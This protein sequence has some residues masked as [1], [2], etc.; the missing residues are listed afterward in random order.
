MTAVAR[1]SNAS[2][3]GNFSHFTF[4]QDSSFAGTYTA[5]GN[6][7]DNDI[8]DFYYAP[9]SGFLALCTKNLPSVD[10]IPSEHFNTVL[11]TGNGSATTLFTGVGFQPDFVWMKSRSA[12]SVLMR[13]GQ[14]AR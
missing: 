11:Y 2:G 13:Y 10:I 12:G 3:T 5:Q 1:A 8:G 4:G 14:C 9:P 7:D 6:Q